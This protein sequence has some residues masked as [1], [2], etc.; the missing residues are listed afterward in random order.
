[1]KSTHHSQ[2]AVTRADLRTAV[3]D[4]CSGLARREA[5]DLVDL[6]L[7]E[8]GEALVSGEPVKL[9]GFGAFNV[10]CKRPGVGRN[11]KTK[12]PAP[13]VARRVLTFKAAPGLIA[14]LNQPPAEL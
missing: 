3:Y 6:M 9:R 10:R 13:I 5:A 2:G 1:M 8:I 11:P 14:R 7:A 4:A 12:T